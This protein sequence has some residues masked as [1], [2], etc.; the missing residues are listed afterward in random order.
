VDNDMGC[1]GLARKLEILAREH[2]PVETD[3]KFHSGI[4]PAIMAT[5][6]TVGKDAPRSPL[7]MSTLPSAAIM[8]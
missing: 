7:G 6:R 3:P 5:R 8:E 2:V 1:P 4:R